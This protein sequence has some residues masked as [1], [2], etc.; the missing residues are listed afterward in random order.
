MGEG[1]CRRNLFI[2]SIFVTI[3]NIVGFSLILANYLNADKEKRD[4]SWRETGA[5]LAFSQTGFWF[6][7]ENLPSAKRRWWVI[8]KP[9]QVAIYALSTVPIDD[10][11]ACDR[12]APNLLTEKALWKWQMMK[13]YFRTNTASSFVISSSRAAALNDYQGYL[14]FSRKTCKQTV[15]NMFRGDDPEYAFSFEIMDMRDPKTDHPMPNYRA[16]NATYYQD[17][18][19]DQKDHRSIT[20]GFNVHK[21]QPDITGN[22]KKDAYILQLNYPNGLPDTV[23]WN[24]IYDCVNFAIPV[25]I[26]MGPNQVAEFDIAPTCDYTTCVGQSIPV[27]F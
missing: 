2:K 25:T 9:L 4:W 17:Y 27:G 20:M 1:N 26:P 6:P 5:V 3:F 8:H 14:I 11:C 7:F 23:T 21:T 18:P 15:L 10:P 12:V 22:L 24:D 13:P 19:K 16:F